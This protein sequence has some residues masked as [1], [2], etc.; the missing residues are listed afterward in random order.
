MAK[1]D[2]GT[3]DSCAGQFQ[4]QLLHNGFGDTTFAY[5]DSCGRTALMSAWYPHVPPEAQLKI[6]GAVNIEAESLLAHCECGGEFHALASPRC[7]KCHAK[8]SAE[9]ATAYIEANALGTAKG[10]RW[11]HSWQGL[12]CIVV[13]GRSI[14]NPW[15]KR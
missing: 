2:V 13:E 9:A 1:T 14:E 3:C 12:Y 8:L 5:C 6:H 7:P 11:Q 10:W 15:Q 4:Y